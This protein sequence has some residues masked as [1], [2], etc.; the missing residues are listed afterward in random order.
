MDHLEWLSVSR[1]AIRE[2]D[3]AALAGMKRLTTISPFAETTTKAWLITDE[4]QSTPWVTSADGVLS[5]RLLSPKAPMRPDARLI[6]VVELCNNSRKAIQV[7][8]LLFGC[9]YPDISVLGPSGSLPF[10]GV[11]S[12]YATSRSMF[13][14]IPPGDSIRHRV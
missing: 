6:L 5:T 8:R 1:T 7:L 9:P 4:L 2:S 11:H 13:I 14:V 3:L 12:D 10:R